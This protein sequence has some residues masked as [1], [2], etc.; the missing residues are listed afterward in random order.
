MLEPAIP[1]LF[2]ERILIDWKPTSW[3]VPKSGEIIARKG[4]KREFEV[5]LEAALKEIKA[6]LKDNGLLIFWFSHRNVDAWKA[7]TEALNAAQFSITAIINDTKLLLKVLR[8]LI[9]EPINKSTSIL[10]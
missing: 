1:L 7:V 8:K 10:S 4:N 3:T 2:N 5:R 6:T 9:N